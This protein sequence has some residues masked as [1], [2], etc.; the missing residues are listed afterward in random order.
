MNLLSGKVLVL[1]WTKML[2]T[3]Q[4]VRFFKVKYLKKEVRDQ[5]DFLHLDKRKSFLQVDTI[6]FGKRV[7]S[8]PKCPKNKF[9]KS[10]QYFKKEVRDEVDFLCR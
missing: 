9:T 1:T 7:H 3:S 10:L 2:L 5:V 8:Y 4:F 6:G